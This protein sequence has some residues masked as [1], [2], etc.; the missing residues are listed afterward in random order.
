M[1]LTTPEEQTSGSMFLSLV[2]LA[3]GRISLVLGVLLAT[4]GGMPL[5]GQQPTPRD[6]FWSAS[7]LV[8]VSPNPGASPAPNPTPAPPR[9]PKPNP[10]ARPHV[11]P[12]L[13][14]KNGYG[15]RPHFVPVSDDQMGLR[16]S[17]LL[18]DG[19]GHYAEVSPKTV[20]HN[21]DHL[22]LSVMANQPGYLYVIEQGSSGNWS[23]LFP[24]PG[25]A[26]ASGGNVNQIEQGRIYQI[27]NGKG[28]F[29]FDRNPGQ[30]K[31]FLVLSRQRI[32]DLDGTI[33]SLGG[34]THQTPADAPTQPTSPEP[35]VLEATNQIPAELVEKMTGRD[36]TLV[37][38]QEVDDSLNGDRSGEKAVYVV[39]KVSSTKDSPRVVVSVTLR[40]E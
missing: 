19:A 12:A 26:A 9:T 23:P 20:F 7:D 2:R 33:S 31:L 25:S 6:T 35:Q 16:Y 32:S 34:S 1:G 14:V 36:L 3:P 28:A 39:S 13:V 37:Q 8:Q 29:Q 21:G 38:E 24:A 18:R 30:E 10:H 17:L 11:D 15:G 40:H 22:R 4:A 27:P 5:T